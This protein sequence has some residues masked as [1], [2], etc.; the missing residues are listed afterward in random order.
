MEKR[1]TH[2]RTL[3]LFIPYAPVCSTFCHV[4]HFCPVIY[5]PPFHTLSALSYLTP[6]YLS[7]T[8]LVLADLS[9]Y[10]IFP[11]L[12]HS[13]TLSLLRTPSPS[14]LC[15]HLFA[16]SLSNQRFNS[17]HLGRTSILCNLYHLGAKL[18]QSEELM[19]RQTR[20]KLSMQHRKK[21]KRKSRHLCQCCNH[22][23]TV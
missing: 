1:S 9:P 16:P 7:L 4:C 17:M 8:L 18:R 2:T 6:L 19:A 13:S 12:S 14:P 20:T 3:Q 15:T 11:G 21:K 22:G 10:F 23:N 5:Y